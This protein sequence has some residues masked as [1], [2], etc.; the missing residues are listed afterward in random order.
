[1]KKYAVLMIGA[2]LSLLS[3]GTKAPKGDLLSLEFVSNGSRLGT[4]YEGHVE[5]DS[6]G[7]FMLTA[8]KMNYGPFYQKK[9]GKEEMNKFKKIILDE[10]MYKYKEH[11][12]PFF[13]IKDG[14]SWRFSAKFSDGSTI[15][16]TGENS[17]PNGNGL[18]MIQGY[19]YD[20]IA[21]ATIEVDDKEIDE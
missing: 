11:Y 18:S 13:D 8:M 21:D 15:H 10:K 4:E 17:K 9:I 12:R 16:S 19:L 6:N 3:C 5:Q 20:L 7:T 1:M 14:H 2:I